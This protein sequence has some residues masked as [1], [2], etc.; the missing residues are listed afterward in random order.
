MG[1]GEGLQW[2]EDPKEV[3]K[4]LADVQ[5]VL[6]NLLEVLGVSKEEF[7]EIQKKKNEKAGSFK[8]KQ[9]IDSVGVEENSEWL[10][11][12]LKN[13]DKYPEI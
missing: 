6:D 4:E 9:Y 2:A 7:S 5:E 8:K 1:E 10:G 11:Y 12:Y 3:T 13:P